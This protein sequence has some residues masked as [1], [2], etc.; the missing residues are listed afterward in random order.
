LAAPSLL[1]LVWP[2]PPRSADGGTGWL[3]VAVVWSVATIIL[4]VAGWLL[5]GRSDQRRSGGLVL[6][7][8]LINSTDTLPRPSRAGR[9]EER[10]RDDPAVMSCTERLTVTVLMSDI[11]GYSAI[12]EVTPPADLAP[13]LNEHRRAMNQ[14]LLGEGGTVLRYVGDAVLAEEWR[15]AGS[16]SFGL[17]IGVSTGPVAAAFLGSD[18]RV[19]YTVIGD[20]VNLTARLTDQARPAGMR[21]CRPTG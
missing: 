2:W 18:E 14:V 5:V 7:L 6:V 4:V 8:A 15:A 11:R 17:G 13:L 12:A 19:E 21:R 16:P 20:T 3:L 1:L 10:L 9:A